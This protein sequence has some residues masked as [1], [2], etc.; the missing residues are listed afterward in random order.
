MPAVDEHLEKEGD[1]SPKTF[2]VLG[3]PRSGTSFVARALQQAGVSMG[4]QALH[5]ENQDFRKL[6]IALLEEARGSPEY[7][8]DPMYFVERDDVRI[9]ERVAKH[10]CD[11]WGW[12]D[13]RQCL[14]FPMFLPHLEDD[15]YIVAVF[16][17]ARRAAASM[18]R[19]NHTEPG[20]ELALYR[21]YEQQVVNSINLLRSVDE[22]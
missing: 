11:M 20:R 18:R 17:K 16:R 2:V 19:H 1:T 14:T 21:Y 6:N 15:V 9:Q 22:T 12:K 7:P 3:A 5:Y 13:V 8:P 10:R 4:G